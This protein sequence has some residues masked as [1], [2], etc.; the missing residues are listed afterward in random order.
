MTVDKEMIDRA[1]KLKYI[2]VFGT[3]YGRIDAEYA[4]RKGITVCNIAGY[5]TEGVAELA[6]ALILE[7]IRDVSRAK[8]QAAAGDY[9]ESSFKG[10]EI[11][12]KKF[13]V[14][15]LGQIGARIA[16][17]AK[18]GFGAN[19]MYH[20]RTKKTDKFKYQK[21]IKDLAQECDFISINLAFNS[22]TEK[23]IN[24]EIINAIKPGA[25]VVNLSPMELVDI[26][27]LKKRLRVGDITFILDHAD[28][29]TEK[30]AKDLSQFDNCILYPPIG[31]ITDEAKLLMRKIFVDNLLNYLDGHP[32]NK[33]N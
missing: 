13:G 3:G 12:G 20:S 9:S 26:E 6:F 8:V 25:V 27:A 2:G 11:A 31:Y 17:I 19:V 33:V 18:N 7:H 28:E 23:C 29:L 16:E 30:Q 24:E 5:S 22:D 4:A 21:N 14:I 15:G 1:Q 32:T 10:S